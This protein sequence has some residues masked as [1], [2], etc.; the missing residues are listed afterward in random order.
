[1]YKLL[2]L[3]SLFSAFCNSE[4]YKKI[5]GDNWSRYVVLYK[6]GYDNLNTYGEVDEIEYEKKLKV[7]KKIIGMEIV[8]SKID[9]TLYNFQ[10][11]KIEIVEKV[12]KAKLNYSTSSSS[13]D[14]LDERSF[15]NTDADYSPLSN[16]GGVNV[17]VVDSGIRGTHSYFNGRVTDVWDF[18]NDD[19][20]AEDC[21]GH[22]TA[23]A[24][25]I[26]GQYTGVAVASNIFS[27]KV[28]GCDREFDSSNLTEALF[29]LDKNAKKPA[30]V[31]LSVGGVGKSSADKI[32]IDRIISRGIVVVA[33]AG[34]ETSD[35]CDF[36][37]AN[38]NG[39]L[40]VGSV[41]S[42]NRISYFS[43]YGKC[44][45]IFAPGEDVYT[46]NKAGDFD[47]SRASSGTSFSAPFVS[48]AAALYLSRKPDLLPSEV[49]DLIVSSSTKNII[50]NSKGSP[51]RFLFL[52]SYETFYDLKRGNEYSANNTY[53]IK[54]TVVNAN[55]VCKEEGYGGKVTN[56]FQCVED[57]TSYVTYSSSIGWHAQETGSSDGC[58]KM[59]QDVE[60]S[61]MKKF[62]NPTR[63]N[64]VNHNAAHKI[65]MT[66]AS[67]HQFCQENGYK[68]MA[69]YLI[70][71]GEDETSFVK[72][73]S[74]LGWYVKESGTTNQCYS[75]FES[76]TCE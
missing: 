39:V 35:A 60:C 54:D 74:D 4:N 16:G 30:V 68:I 34:N 73:S 52:G 31:N 57:E 23:V 25:I 5:E 29:W 67:G 12:V 66:D 40:T 18:F 15:I 45:D 70:G 64:E 27:L 32:L 19:A 55:Q 47:V 10:S 72:F 41:D 62:N 71:C 14:R 6:K 22:G 46:T 48:G 3:L 2:F 44:V 65:W 38:I 33:A 26:A 36:T 1:M 21:N 20:I 13:L 50:A 24:G 28:G 37:P 43:N 17:Y 56:T 8:E 49:V 53:P 76:I 59:L 42:F 11:D 58:Y 61:S 69:D 63:W 75:I 9:L 51:N 7:I